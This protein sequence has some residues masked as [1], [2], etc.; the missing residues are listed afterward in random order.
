[1]RIKLETRNAFIETGKQ[2]AFITDDLG[3]DNQSTVLNQVS[4]FLG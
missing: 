4:Y 3:I 1:M 2:E